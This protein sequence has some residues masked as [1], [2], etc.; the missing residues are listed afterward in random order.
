MNSS[1]FCLVLALGFVLRA[2][3]PPQFEVASVKVSTSGFNGVRGGCHGIDSKYSATELGAAPPLGRCV[4][5]DGR[6]SHL[7]GIAYNL[8]MAS[9]KNA[10]DWVMAGSDRFTIEA[11][12][13]DPSKATEKEILGML[14][15]LLADRFQLKFHRETKDMPGF[16]L[17]VAKN[18]PTLQESTSD[19]GGMS[20]GPSG[21][22]SQ[23]GPVNITLR[24]YSPGM[25]AT[26]LAQVGSGPVVDQTGLTGVYDISLAWNETD[27]PSLVTAVREQLGLRLEPQKVPVSYFMFDSAQKPGAN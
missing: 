27:G 19:Q 3:T 16:A 22:P 6:L 8:P 11:K 26:L 10:P 21:K 15:L 5:T 24:R 23:S 1:R 4:I 7:I 18:G 17:T 14:Q 9:I 2:E 25:L 12:A 13:E 20:F